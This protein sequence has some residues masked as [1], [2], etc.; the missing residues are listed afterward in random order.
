MILTWSRKPCL[1]AYNGLSPR[2][3]TYLHR[4]MNGAVVTFPP[5]FMEADCPGGLEWA[6]HAFGECIRATSDKISTAFGVI[7]I[8][9][10]ILFAIPQILENY[11]KKIPDAAVSECLLIFSLLVDTLNFIGA[12]L[13]GQL[14]LQVTGSML[15]C[16]IKIIIFPV[17][18]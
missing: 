8:A 13:A 7:C 11:S 6:W 12:F 16:Q 10:W 1:I 4:V 3:I 2:S 17:M 14:I 18:F 9:A 15:K 5:S